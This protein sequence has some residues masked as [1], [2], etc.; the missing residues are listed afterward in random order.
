[1]IEDLGKVGY[2]LPVAAGG[3]AGPGLEIGWLSA[4]QRLMVL[5]YR[6]A[7]GAAGAD[8]DALVPKL[9]DLAKKIDMTT[10]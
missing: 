4:N 9:V 7:D 8:L 5:R 2:R 6:S 10:D 1:V 3:G